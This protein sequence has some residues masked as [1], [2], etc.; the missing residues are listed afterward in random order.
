MIYLVLAIFYQ[1]CRYPS[2]EQQLGMK[3]KLN[4]SSILTVTV[5]II[6][7]KSDMKCIFL[8]WYNIIMTLKDWMPFEKKCQWSKG[9]PTS[10][11]WKTVIR[12]AN[13]ANGLVDMNFMQLNIILNTKLVFSSLKYFFLV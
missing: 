12:V 10:S 8:E 6:L 1:K 4:V 7:Y 5:I 2:N 9:N 11:L 3:N 13:I